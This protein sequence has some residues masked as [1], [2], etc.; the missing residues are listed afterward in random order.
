MDT[1]ICTQCITVH[2]YELMVVVFELCKMA[3]KPETTE[4]DGI[5]TLVCMKAPGRLLVLLV[6][7]EQGDPKQDHFS[8][9]TKICKK[10]VKPET[11]VH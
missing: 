9:L 2:V 6:A 5:S 11:A 10:A 1:F 7:T 3:A 4:R 8:T